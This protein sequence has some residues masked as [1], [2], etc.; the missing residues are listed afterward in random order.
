MHRSVSPPQLIQAAL[1]VWLVGF[2]GLGFSAEVGTTCKGPPELEKAISTRPSAS[3]YDALGAYFG[4]RNQ[5]KCALSAFESAVRLEP[6]SWEPHYNLGLALLESGKPERAAS[7]LRAAAR[8]RPHMAQTHTALGTALSKSGQTD[9]AVGEFKLALQLD[10]TFVPAEDGLAQ[11][12]IAQ[13][14][15]VAAIDYL[16]TLPPSEV[17]QMDLAIAY[18]RNGNR[19]QAIHILS[20]LIKQNPSSAQAHTNLATVYVQQSRYREAAAEF[21]KAFSLDP[22]D[23]I[24]L[25]SYVRALAVLGEFHSASPVIGNYVRR[26]PRNVEALY[27]MGV[28][29]RGLGNYIDAEKM[30]RRALALDPNDYDVRY[31]LGFVLAKLGK[32]E[33][34]R[35]QFDK[36]LQINPASSEARFQRAAVLRTLGQKEEATEELRVVEQQKEQSFRQDIA[37]TKTNQ[38]NG[39]FQAGE[40]QRA[41]NLYRDAIAEDPNNARSYFNLAWALDKLGDKK[42]ERDAL[43]KAVVVDAQFA[44][45]HNQLGLLSLATGQDADA[46]KHL[47]IAISINPQY[48]EAQNNLGVLCG[49]QGKIKESEQL[50]RQAVENDPHYAQAFL[51]LGLTL[52]S[53]SHFAEAQQTVQNAIQLEPNNIQA[54]TARGMVLA[55]MNRGPEAVADFRKVIELDSSSA[56]AHLNLGIALADL[57][58]LEHALGEFSEAVRLDPAASVPRYNLGRALLDLGRNAEAKVELEAV[59]RMDPDFGDCWYLLGL[60]E[61]QA[62]NTDQSIQRLKTAVQLKPSNADALYLLGQGLLRSGDHAGAIAQWR[63]AIEVRPDYSEALY[64][65][66]RVLAKSDPEEAKRLQNQFE[67]LQAQEHITDRAQTLGNFALASADARDWPQAIAQLKEGIKVCGDCGAL[68]LLKKDIGLI[69]CRSGDL[70]AGRAEL[71]EAQKLN[72]Q[73]PEI[74]QALRFLENANRRK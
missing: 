38:A 61:K 58:D 66:S 15:Y 28:V 16:K 55:K 57:F 53:Q 14:K 37:G 49:K 46:E 13:K 40:I 23:E 31:N 48:A 25:I 35:E 32:P 22:T 65:L 52:A 27:L 5:S 72:A 19:D 17:L 4:Q 70:K 41:V 7:E 51:N 34:A 73:D 18:S 33:E 67:K 43:E 62:G 8:L 45:A 63:K 12:L 26:K 71:L 64:N 54:L 6:N 42:G 24:A 2:C 36:A 21:Q 11:A 20:E 50:F 30:L 9:N 39:Y 3:A 47:K 60:I 74:E 56:E 68:P 29:H 1:R 59:T 44:A 69:Y 10:P